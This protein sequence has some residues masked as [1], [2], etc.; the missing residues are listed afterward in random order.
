MLG[1]APPIG[2]CGLERVDNKAYRW[3][4]TAQQMG[5][6]C[7][8]MLRGFKKKLMGGYVYKG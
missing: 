3:M 2:S 5:F 4:A 6:D 1:K 8:E 7:Q